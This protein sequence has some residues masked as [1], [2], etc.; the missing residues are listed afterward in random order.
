MHNSGYDNPA[1]TFVAGFI[2]NP[3]MN[4]MEGE[5]RDGTFTGPNVTIAGFA[6]VADGP[7]T[8]G[9]RAEDA[10]VS[11]G[12]GQVS[13]PV[14]SME[15]LGDSTMM[16]VKAGGGLVAVKAGKDF[17]TRIGAA[18]AADVPANICHLFDTKTGERI[19]G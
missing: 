9:F 17:R 12:A 14:Y 18:F 1:N 13:A 4:L 2:G 11:E 3:A 7:V 5:M 16:T 15:L 6:G 8:C 19:G 10:S